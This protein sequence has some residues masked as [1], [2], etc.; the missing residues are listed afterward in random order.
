MKLMRTILYLATALLLVCSSTLVSISGEMATREEC[1]AKVEEAIKLIQKL[2]HEAAFEKISDENGSFKWKDSHVFCIDLAT[3]ILLAHPLSYR[4]GFA[5]KLYTDANGGYPYAEILDIAETEDQ[6]WTTYLSD[7]LGKANP[8]LKHMYFRKVP[9][10]NIVLCSGYYVT[11]KAN[12][13]N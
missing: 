1:E 13:E 10:E 5:M 7:S 12:G 8:R 11:S 9:G 3:G 4:V 2:G 6:G